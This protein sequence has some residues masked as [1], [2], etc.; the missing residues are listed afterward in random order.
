MMKK[1]L[2]LFISIIFLNGCTALPKNMVPKNIV[3]IKGHSKPVTIV[4]NGEMVIEGGSTQVSNQAFTEAIQLSIMKN[5]LFSKV[6]KDV[7]DGFLLEV[8]IIGYDPPR[9]ALN[10]NFNLT[11]TLTTRWKLKL[12]S[13]QEVVFDDFIKKVYTAT[14]GAELVA[15][16]RH[17]AANEGVVRDTIEEGI[18]MISKLDLSK[19]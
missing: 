12:L 19:K 17:R 18:N 2:M 7:E 9:G 3:A 14:V 6:N 15:T 1:I 5:N 10:L 11:S 16:I 4:V 13:N 8:F